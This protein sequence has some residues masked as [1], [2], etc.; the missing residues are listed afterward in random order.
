MPGV[1]NVNNGRLRQPCY[2]RHLKNTTDCKPGVQTCRSSVLDCQLSCWRPAPADRLPSS[3]A[4]SRPS[5]LVP[6]SPIWSSFSTTRSGAYRVSLSSWLLSLQAAAAAPAGFSLSYRRPGLRREVV[7]GGLEGRPLWIPPRPPRGMGPETG[8]RS[9]GEDCSLGGTGL[10][11]QRGKLW[12]T[13]T[14]GNF[15]N[16]FGSASIRRIPLRPLICR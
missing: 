1:G 8:V 10:M 5:A 15:V 2:I 13:L 4:S 6:S 14:N 3:Q 11:G 12:A 16:L 7:S 9:G